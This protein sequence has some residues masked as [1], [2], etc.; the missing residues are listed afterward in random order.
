MKIGNVYK[1]AS[2]FCITF[3]G[4]T[5]GKDGFYMLIGFSQAGNPVFQDRDMFFETNEEASVI[6]PLKET[7]HE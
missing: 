3:E 1:V 6:E 2:R 7:P 4:R 5:S